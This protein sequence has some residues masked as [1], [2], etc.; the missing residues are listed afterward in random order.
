MRRIPILLL[1]LATLLGIATEA[2]AA[3]KKPALDG[4]MLAQ[5]CFACHGPA[6]ASVAAPMPIIGGQQAVYLTNVLQAFRSGERSST[7]MGRLMRGY[8]DQEVEAIANYL[9]S[10]PFVPAAQTVD[11]AKAAAGQRHYNQVCKKCH[12]DAGRDS[13]EPDYPRLAGQ[14]LPYLQATTDEILTG[15]RKVDDKFSTSLGKLTRDEI[16]AVVHFFAAQK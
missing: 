8:S 9:N 2:A 4:A 7:I 15:Q 12:L 10:L 1:S 13:S 5:S 6:G 3:R 16:D 11:P 14:W